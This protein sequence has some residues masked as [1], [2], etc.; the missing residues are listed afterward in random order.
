[1]KARRQSKCLSNLFDFNFD[2]NDNNKK[3]K[4]IRPK[5][6]GNHILLYRINSKRRSSPTSFSF[7]SK[8]PQSV[9]IKDNLKNFAEKSHPFNS[10]QAHIAFDLYR[11]LFV[12]S[13]LFR[14]LAHSP[15]FS[16][17]KK[18]KVSEFYC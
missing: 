18:K 15:F 4:A 8:T 6:N 14:S 5:F 16:Y 7:P 10:T 3:R 11:S 9:F 17:P 12:F 13:N 2:T 1:M